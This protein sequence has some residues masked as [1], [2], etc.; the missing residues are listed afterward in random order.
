MRLAWSRKRRK[1]NVI[2]LAGLLAGVLAGTIAALSWPAVADARICTP[3]ANGA[4]HDGRHDDTAAIQRAIEACGAG[5]EILLSK[6]TYLS[7]PLT[8]SSG[9]T[10]V[11]AGGATLLGTADH[12]AYRDGRG[13][14]VVPLISARNAHDVTLSGDGTIDGQG[15]SWW[16][17]FKAARAAGGDLPLRPKLVVFRDVT[18]LKVAGLTLRNSPM[19]HLVIDHSSHVLVEGL[20]IRAPADS[21]NTDGI[22]PSGRDM[23]FRNLTID[24]GD[25]NIAVKSGRDDPAHPGAASAN[26]VVRDCTFLHGHGLSIGSETTGGVRNMLAENIT[27]TGTRFGIRIKTSRGKGGAVDDL[28]YRNLRMDHV[29][30]AILITA[31]YPRILAHDGPRPIGPQTP[32][33]H[34]ITIEHVTAENAGSAGGLIGLPERP[35]R[36]IRLVDVVIHAR[37]GMTVRNASATLE[38]RILVDTGPAIIN[39]AGGSLTEVP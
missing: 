18:N 26:I 3:E 4:V 13:R 31:Y 21:P 6:G 24:V 9:D 12:E 38:G 5:D 36:G 10:F 37:K 15:A 16:S 39:E 2:H 25:D 34:D 17:A 11:V 23:L 35:L 27:F 1:M 32:D 28:T 33:I 14:T 30:E 22:D 19:F 29:G 7:R 20:T 8:L